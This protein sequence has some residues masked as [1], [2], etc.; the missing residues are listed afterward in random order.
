MAARVL[1]VAGGPLALAGVSFA[2]ESLDLAVWDFP[3]TAALTR[4]IL[5]TLRNALT[6]NAR[7]LLCGDVPGLVAIEATAEVA[8]FGRRRLEQGSD[9]N[10]VL[11]LER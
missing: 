8:G 3:A 6:P 5:I 4:E 11:C 7:F 10:G 1:L 9:G 2:R